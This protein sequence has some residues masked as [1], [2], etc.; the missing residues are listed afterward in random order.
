MLPAQFAQFKNNPEKFIAEAVRIIREQKAT[1]VVEHIKYNILDDVY[2]ADI[3]TRNQMIMPSNMAPI[4]DDGQMLQKHI[5]EYLNTDSK[6]E[7]DFA[8]ELDNSTEVVVYAKL[9][10]GFAIP[11]PL[12]NYNPDWA[13]AFQDGAVKHIY[14]VA[15]TKGDLSG[16]QLRKIEEAKIACAEKYFLSLGEKDARFHVAYKK[17]ASYRNLIDAANAD[18]KEGAFTMQNMQS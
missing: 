13:I 2:D 16:L 11:T 15:E 1:M 10:R 17:V 6:G 3:F 12:G 7:K 14:F 18:E 8:K 9:P 4:R 5:Y